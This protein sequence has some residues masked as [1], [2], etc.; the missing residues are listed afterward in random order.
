MR[1][2]RLTVEVNSP[3]KEMDYPGTS[4][5]HQLAVSSKGQQGD[6]SHGPEGG[7]ATI[8]HNKNLPAD[9]YVPILGTSQADL[10]SCAAKFLDRCEREGELEMSPCA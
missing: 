2:E 3:L 8:R 7:R 1:F 9:N 4:R 6:Q 10:L 5:D